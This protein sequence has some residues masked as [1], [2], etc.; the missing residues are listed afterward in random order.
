MADTVPAWRSDYKG[1]FIQ[2]SRNARKDYSIDWADWLGSDTIASTE[3]TLDAHLTQAGNTEINGKVA[4]F[5]LVTGAVAGEWA[6]VFKLT[7]GDGNIEYV[8]FRVIVR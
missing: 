2:M 3:I 5:T 1:R 6:C 8:P 4:K 7:S